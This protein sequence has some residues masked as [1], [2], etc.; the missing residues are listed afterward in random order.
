MT[1]TV[2][3]VATTLL[4]SPPAEAS[5]D[6][7]AWT[8]WIDDAR[9]QI[10]NRLGD[11]ALLDQDDLD[12]VVRESVALKVKRP[13]PATQISVSIDDGTISKSYEKGAGQVTITDEWWDLLTPEA[14]D[15]GAWT[16]KPWA[17]R[18]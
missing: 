9:R 17:R 5:L 1:V 2:A 3:N 10:K 18:C 7:A 11:L 16:I 15:N 13:D 6:W 4:R 8:M 14:V 12:Y